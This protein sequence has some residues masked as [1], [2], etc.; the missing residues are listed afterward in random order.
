MDNKDLPGELARVIRGEVDADPV[1]EQGEEDDEAEIE[2]VVELDGILAPLTYRGLARAADPPASLAGAARRVA[3]AVLCDVLA[4]APVSPA[5]VEA[6]ARGGSVR[7]ALD[8]VIAPGPGDRAQPEQQ[9]RP[10][11]GVASENIKQH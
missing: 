3:E 10:H 4:R 2:L 6:G 1:G 9:T 8:P 5:A 11:V 7:R